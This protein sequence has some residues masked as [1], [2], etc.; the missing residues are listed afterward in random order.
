MPLAT[1]HS[2]AL[3]GVSAQPILIEV[4]LAN[5]L[6][7]LTIV[8]LPEASVR[9]SKERV[10][11]AIT[12]SGF[13]Y[14]ARRITVNLAPADIPKFGSGYDLAIAIG[15]LQASEQIKH[16]ALDQYSFM[17]ELSLSGQ[18]RPVPGLLPVALQAQDDHLQLVAA[19]SSGEDFS[20][21]DSQNILCANSL[22]QVSEHLEEGTPL[23]PPSTNTPEIRQSV[24]TELC[25]SDVQGQ[26][27]AKRALEIAAAGGHSLLMQGPPGT[28]KTMLASRIPGIM[29]QLGA[30]EA[31]EVAS[32]YS[33]SS[34][35]N[36]NPRIPPFRSPHHTCSQVALVGGGSKP[37]PGEI[38]LAHRGV[39]FL[40]ELPEFPSRVLEVLRQPME[41]GEVSVSRAAFKAMFPARFQ[42]IAAMNPCPCGYLG[43]SRCRCT[44]DR[45]AQYQGRISGPLL[46]R[47][48]MHIRLQ[49]AR[50][51]ISLTGSHASEHSTSIRLRVTRCQ[52][53]QLDRQGV[54]NAGLS[55]ARIQAMLKESPILAETAQQAIDRMDLSMRAIHRVIRVAQTIAD[56][57]QATLAKAH[58]LEA[59]NFRQQEIRGL[60]GSM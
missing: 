19:N 26:Q 41:S 32:I 40:D 39:L 8:G 15:I 50:Q 1:V 10:R 5:G 34:L 2:Y 60:N 4:H 48:D 6:P 25:L 36:P 59:L 3:L 53:R 11:S 55:G 28:G 51:E 18:L 9:E 29:P 33:I 56:L 13:E 31:V 44:P 14:P 17:G 20:L 23:P 35:P 43:E 52:K 38:S 58:M 37:A 7:G 42:L 47:I 45:V 16:P 24:E 22:C 30:R 27:Q 49:R 57:D 12:N 21:I 54:L 46:D